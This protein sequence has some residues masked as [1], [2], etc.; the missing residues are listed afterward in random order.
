[1]LDERKRIIYNAAISCEAEIT[2]EYDLLES[3]GA[4]GVAAI[5]RIWPQLPKYFGD[6]EVLAGTSGQAS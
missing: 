2:D 5:A 3:R 4:G 6:E 1:V